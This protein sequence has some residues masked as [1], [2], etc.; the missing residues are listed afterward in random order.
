MN[1]RLEDV[2]FL[3]AHLMGPSSIV[4]IKELTA[5]LPLQ[6]GMRVLDLGCGTGLT[7][8][9][10]AQKFDVTV[11]AVDLWIP[12]TENYQ[13]F[14]A[15]GLEEQIVPIHADACRLPFAQ[16]YFDAVIS[17]DAYHY[18]G[19]NED[20]LDSHLS[21]LVKEGGLF[22]VAVPGFKTE[23]DEGVPGPL[24]P[25]LP[26][27]GADLHWHTCDWWQALWG[28]SPHVRVEAVREMD[29]FEEAWH[30]WLQCDNPYARD[31]IPLLQADDGRYMNLIKMTATKI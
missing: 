9:Y 8:I 23:V 31:N 14:R 29:C 26:P 2:D 27:A 15:F 7:S 19:A 16:S 21:P 20:Y 28:R 12:A 5:P 18:F 17:V 30:E 1:N 6:K 25:F 11:F 4:M 22:A 3:R 13:R 24:Q 10:L